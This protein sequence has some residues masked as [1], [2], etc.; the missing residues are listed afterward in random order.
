MDEGKTQFR[1]LIHI[2]TLGP[3]C[4]HFQRG[5]QKTGGVDRK[6]QH[7]TTM[8][9]PLVRREREAKAEKNGGGPVTNGMI[10]DR[11]PHTQERNLPGGANWVVQKFGG[12]SVG[13][14]AVQI[15]EDIVLYVHFFLPM[16]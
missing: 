2:H 1:S 5:A 4:Q 7:I 13:K 8:E 15:A 10:E 9:F 16:R 12:T 6:K 14:F 11:I 3:P